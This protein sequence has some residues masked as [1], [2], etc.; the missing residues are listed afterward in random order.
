MELA[1]LIAERKG[2]GLL[3]TLNVRGEVSDK[4]EG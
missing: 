1:S 3:L 4:K 2:E